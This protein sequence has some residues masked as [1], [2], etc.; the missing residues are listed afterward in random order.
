MVEHADKYSPAF[1]KKGYETLLAG[2]VPE[3]EMWKYSSHWYQNFDDMAK[4]TMLRQL[5]S[6]WGIMSIQ[7]QQAYENDNKTIFDNGQANYLDDSISEFDTTI[8]EPEKIEVISEPSEK[9]S[10]AVKKSELKVEKTTSE[11]KEVSLDEL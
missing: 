4:K 3:K 10:K 5:I 6:K 1:S 7:M 11:V 9:K 2:K 8:I